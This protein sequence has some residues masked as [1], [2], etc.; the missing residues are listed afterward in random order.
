[1]W[2]ELRVVEYAIIVNTE[3]TLTQQTELRMET[4]THLRAMP[5]DACS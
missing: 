2:R 5:R 1:M 4:V 3:E